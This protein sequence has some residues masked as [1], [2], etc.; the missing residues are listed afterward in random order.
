M[1]VCKYSHN[2]LGHGPIRIA[3][4]VGLGTQRLKRSTAN[5]K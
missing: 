5:K 1:R 2:N 3:K 4:T